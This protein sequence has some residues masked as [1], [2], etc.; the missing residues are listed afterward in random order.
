MF[1]LKILKLFVVCFFLLGI[2]LKLSAQDSAYDE[3]AKELSESASQLKSPKIAL[4]PFSYADKTE[5]DDG[6]GTVVSERLT[7]KIVKLKKFLVI[8]R[9]N[10][11]KVLSEQKLQTSGAVD[12]ETA[13]KIGKVLGVE[14]IITGTLTNIAG[15]MV[16]VNAKLIRTETAEILNVSSSKIEKDWLSNQAVQPSAPQQQAYQ[17]EVQPIQQV[18]PARKIKMDS[19]LDLFLAISAG[20]KGDV[21][22][23]NSRGFSRNDFNLN[24][25]CPASFTKFTLTNS[26]FDMSNPIGIR[27]SFFSEKGYVGGAFDLMYYSSQLATQITKA[28]FN[29]GAASDF[30]LS[31]SDYLKITT[32]LFDFD[33]M[34]RYPGKIVQPYIGFG[35]GL[36]INSVSSSYIK[37]FQNGVYGTGFS[38]TDLGVGINIPI[39]IRFQFNN[40]IGAFLES[41]T[42]TNNINFSRNYVSGDS[43]TIAAK[44]SFTMLGV[45]F[46]M[47]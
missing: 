33:L 29:G 27:A 11:E 42:M 44:N 6:G 18:Q 9:Q 45:S 43:D 8:D 32:F 24:S 36:S 2:S 28:S 22:F 20:G 34:V 4:V 3:M 16:E 19:Y 13:K 12:P 47:K 31:V 41:R 10:L 30:N 14:A 39:G 40:D 25:A 17:E 15:G 5:K 21:T 1:K 26:T 46:K 37:G 35:L 38:E 7:N 23:Q